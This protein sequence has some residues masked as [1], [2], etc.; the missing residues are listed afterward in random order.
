MRPYV[1]RLVR[2]LVPPA[3][4][5]WR[6][7]LLARGLF[8]TGYATWSE[9]SSAAVGYAESSILDKVV[10]ATRDVR[11]GR[12]QFERDGVTFQA[13]NINSRL[14]AALLR[15]VAL[16]SGRLHVIDFGGS[17]GSTW[18][19]H[20]Q[21]LDGLDRLSWEVVEQAHFVE[22]GKRE[23][24]VGPLRF[25]NSLAECSAAPGES[26]IV[27]SI[28]LNYLEDPWQ[29]LQQM[30]ACGLRSI[31]L[32][33]TGLVENRQTQLAVQ[34]VPRSIYDGSYPCWLF[35]REDLLR[36]FEHAYSLKCEWECD[37]LSPEGV[38]FAGMYLE[39]IS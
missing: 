30:S 39:R 38:R 29:L 6:R 37:D 15:A 2:D 19:Q 32:D 35:N 4:M 23:F 21:W 9:A 17:L 5:R 11:D 25:R 18:W 16:N 10:R 24:E 34:H 12:A 7:D 13:P 3:L 1:K 22:A 31:F 26:I 28:V 8:T 36:G 14:V 33:R 27:L 20:R